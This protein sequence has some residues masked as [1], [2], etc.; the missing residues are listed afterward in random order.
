[1]FHTMSLPGAGFVWH[2][3]YIVLFYSD[4]GLVNGP[5]YKEYALV[6]LYGENEGEYKYSEN[7]ISVKRTDEF[8]GWEEWKNVNKIG[9]ECEVSFKKKAD[10]IILKTKNLGID[11]ENVTTLFDASTKVYIALTGDQIALTDIRVL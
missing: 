2:C 8:K 3:P 5:N 1:M 9:M 10:R 11:L 4:N 7:S 6:K